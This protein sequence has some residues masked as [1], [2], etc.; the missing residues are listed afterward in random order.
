[1]V[2]KVIDV[3]SGEK[4][5]YKV[6]K[7]GYKTITEEIDIV[8]DMP[9]KNTYNLV[10]SNEEYVP[11]F[12]YNVDTTLECVPMI[13][14]SEKP[15]TP[16]GTEINCTKYLLAPAGKEY[17]Y[18]DNNNSDTFSRVGNVKINQNGTVFNFSS[19]NY[20]KTPTLD[21]G[22][23]DY[24]II[25]EFTPLS[26]S[27]AYQCIFYSSQL[28]WFNIAITNSYSGNYYIHSNTGNHASTWN[29]NIIG[30]TPLELNKT[31]L[32]KTTRISGIRYMYLSSDNGENWTLEGQ[33]AD[34]D[35]YSIDYLI[36]TAPGSGNEY[37]G[38]IGL[39]NSYIKINDELVWK[40]EYNKLPNNVNVVGPMVIDNSI[41]K[42]TFSSSCYCDTY[43]KDF[44]RDS[45]TANSWEWVFKIEKYI[46][47]GAVQVLY[48][49]GRSYESALHVSAANK[50]YVLLNNTANDSYFGG[51][52]SETI[53]EEGK[54]YWLKL[55][56]TGTEYK[57]LLSENG[58]SWTLEASITSSTKLIYGSSDNW[59][60]GWN[61]HSSSSYHYPLKS[62][63]NLA[64][65]YIKVNGEFW[66][67]GKDVYFRNYGT[68]NNA[69]YVQYGDLLTNFSGSNYLITPNVPSIPTSYE[70]VMRYKTNTYNDSRLI[71]NHASNIHSLQIELN[72][73]NSVGVYHPSASYSWIGTD[74]QYA[75]E[76]NKWYWIK[77][78]WNMTDK[79][80]IV[81]IK[82]DDTDW[83]NI[84]EIQADS[85]GWDQ[86]VEIGAD[87]GTNAL[88]ASSF[89][90]LKQSYI[91]FN[92]KYYWK[93][94]EGPIGEYIPG[95]LDD[96]ELD[97]GT[98]KT[99]KL[100]DIQKNSRSLILSSDRNVNI[101]DVKFSE[102]MTEITI[103]EHDLSE[104]DPTTQMWVKSKL[105]E[106]TV[107]DDNTII[108]V[109][110]NS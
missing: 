22:T 49:Q 71:G 70:V 78:T 19:Q 1:M 79:K 9:T 14:F 66:W 30:V 92:D 104:Y 93:P 27:S 102:Y 59:H 42:S 6:I 67:R 94:V 20:L 4:V 63:L 38:T 24:E 62:E 89:V 41:T 97:E 16:D 5:I 53:L 25:L 21:F 46:P 8:A 37:F 61:Y 43:P 86:S 2:S 64:E 44:T 45:G 23:G 12:E 55:E 13:T 77:C 35:T 109:E 11:N 105:I 82:T 58:I 7:D 69:V 110:T 54:S 60:I 91:K 17:L 80:V 90:D 15:I 34:T 74:M 33:H 72:D 73:T 98:E 28:C 88:S 52:Y 85:C 83:E 103:P 76:L 68:L 47:S 107:E 95:I 26:W 36:G 100:I 96:N 106:I 87:Q 108:Y 3:N 31:Y 56:F 10:P 48:S 84:G 18:V 51:L 50:P 57:L 65:S 32:V 81:Y 40:G 29:S 75:F 101:E 39:K 99:Y